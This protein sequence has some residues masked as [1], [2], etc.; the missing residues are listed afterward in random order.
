MKRFSED[1]TALKYHLSTYQIGRK[2]STNTEEKKNFNIDG[3][4]V[5]GSEFRV[6]NRNKSK[7]FRQ[8]DFLWITVC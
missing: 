5:W 3:G 8:K 7:Y 4:S 6:R 2:Q 1:K